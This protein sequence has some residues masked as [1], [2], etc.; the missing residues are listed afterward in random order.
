MR[1]YYLTREIA[2]SYMDVRQKRMILG[3][4]IFIELKKSL[5]DSI[6]S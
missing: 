4:L 3:R 6:T 2:N 1:A 5:K